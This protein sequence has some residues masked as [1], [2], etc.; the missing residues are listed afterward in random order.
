MTGRALG[1][2]GW[3]RG[4]TG[5]VGCGLR[6]EFGPECEEDWRGDADGGAELAGEQIGGNLGAEL[7]GGAGLIGGEVGKFG[8]EVGGARIPG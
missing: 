5:E 8:A 1:G 7:A 2:S 3:T 4:V 6:G